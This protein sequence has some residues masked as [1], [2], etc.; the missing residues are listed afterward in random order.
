[1]IQKNSIPPG[2]FNTRVLKVGIAALAIG[3]LILLASRSVGGG[4][5]GILLSGFL[6][7]VVF[8]LALSVVRGIWS[9][10]TRV[11][12]R[13][14]ILGGC[15][16][17]IAACGVSGLLLFFGYQLILGVIFGLVASVVTNRTS[18]P[19]LGQLAG[20]EPM[21]DSAGG[22]S[23]LNLL[24]RRGAALLAL[25][26]V[27]AGIAFAGFGTFRALEGVSDATDLFCAHPCGM[28]NGLWVQVM[29]D[30]QGRTVA[31]LDPAAVQL[32]VRFWDD[33]ASSKTVNQNTFTLKNPPAVYAPLADRPGCHP[34]PSRTLHL[35]ESTGVLTVC[36]AIPQSENVDFDQLI[37]EWAPASSTAPGG[38]MAPILLGKK[39][40][41]GVSFN[42]EFNSG[43]SPSPSPPSSP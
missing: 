19:T 33:V 36:F 43:Y 5:A 24:P 26:C 35:D 6:A 1:M 14:S 34:W 8:D 2:H 40:R 12:R 18:L 32:R 27:V 7:W 23:M 3:L 21:P 16:V 42:I 4:V 17:A 39:P 15:L 41:T 10:G 22:A 20:I 38:G 9:V 13:H 11:E 25:L 37:L 29:P 31:R 30:S 28:V